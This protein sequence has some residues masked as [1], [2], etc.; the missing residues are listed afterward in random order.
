MFRRT[1]PI[2]VV[3]AL[4]ALAGCRAG[5]S[6]ESSGTPNASAP[7]PVRTVRPGQHGPIARGDFE[8]QGALSVEGEYSLLYEFGDPKTD[9]C[10]KI[11]SAAAGTYVVP[12]PTFHEEQRFGWTAGLRD[13]SGPGTYDLTDLEVVTLRIRKNTNADPVEYTSGRGATVEVVVDKDNGGSMTFKDLRT[14]DGDEKMSGTV[15]WTC[16]T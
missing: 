11:A 13:Y 9:T 7:V 8:F 10:G 2:I 4:A 14:E 3:G 1:A 6:P 15:D 12:L 16:S 5:G